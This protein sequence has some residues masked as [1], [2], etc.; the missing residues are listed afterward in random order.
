MSGPVLRADYATPEAFLAA[1]DAEVT[2]GGLLVR[3][4]AVGSSTAGEGCSVEIRIAGELLVTMPAHIAAVA[5]IGVAVTFE[6]VPEVL[7]ARARRLRGETEEPVADEPEPSEH[8]GETQEP[9]ARGT[10]AERIATLTV[11]QRI[12]L[13]ISGDRETRIALFRDHNK[14]LHAYVLR[15][16]RIAVDEV[17]FAAKMTTISPDALKVIGEH[18]EWAVN[19]AIAVAVTRNPKTPM[20]IALRLLPRLPAGEIR[21]IAK[22]GAREQLVQAARKILS[23]GK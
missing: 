7:A 2:A 16:P 18:K 15:N 14:A 5:R 19:P 13:A 17:T 9:P 6:G 3:G 10:V 21:A 22:G 20:P 1:F 11:A 8:V 12:A 23:A 4:A